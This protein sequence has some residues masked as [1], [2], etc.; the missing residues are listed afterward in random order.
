V[1][2][3][4]IPSQPVGPR[5]TQL[6]AEQ[7]AIILREKKSELKEQFQHEQGFQASEDDTLLYVGV[8]GGLI[9]NKEREF[10]DVIYVAFATDTGPVIT[11]RADSVVLL[12]VNNKPY[13][14]EGAPALN[15]KKPMFQGYRQHMVEPILVVS[16]VVGTEGN[17]IWLR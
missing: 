8:E 11:G 12:D 6:G 5:E 10:A 4:G 14:Q 16:T 17:R 7:R 3:T 1:L 15:T 9:L 2:E 13:K